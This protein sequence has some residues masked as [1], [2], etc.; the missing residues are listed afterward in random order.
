ME[1]G[2]P[3]MAGFRNGW[4]P[5]YVDQARHTTSIRSYALVSYL[6]NGLL[7][8]SDHCQ[9]HLEAFHSLNCVGDVGRHYD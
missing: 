9:Q 8:L 2:I 1:T 7:R 3:E 5:E 6:F 4:F